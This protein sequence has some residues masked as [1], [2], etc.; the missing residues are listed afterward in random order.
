[1][2]TQSLYKDR[3]MVEGRIVAWCLVG[4]CLRQ[5]KQHPGAG[6]DPAPPALRARS[7]TSVESHCSLKESAVMVKGRDLP[8]CP[9]RH[10]RLRNV[11]LFSCTQLCLPSNHLP[12]APPQT[13]VGG[14][15]S[16]HLQG[17][18]SRTLS[19]RAKWILNQARKL[20]TPS[21]TPCVPESG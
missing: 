21:A 6:W 10:K 2:A 8:S 16:W 18:L 17:P 9:I 12:Q 5:Q 1:M 14:G 19:S 7:L 4:L 15:R 11:G 13:R 20:G 3:K